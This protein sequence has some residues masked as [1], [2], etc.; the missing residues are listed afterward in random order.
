MKWSK[1]ELFFIGTAVFD[2]KYLRIPV[3]ASVKILKTTVLRKRSEEAIRK[4]I[5]KR[6]YV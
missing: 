4:Q 1:L 3:K 5:R 2:I 6:L